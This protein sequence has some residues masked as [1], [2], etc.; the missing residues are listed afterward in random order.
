MITVSELIKAG[1]VILILLSGVSIYSIAI[2]LERW[3]AYRKIAKYY[4]SLRQKMTLL[5]RNGDLAPVRDF[6]TLND[7]PTSSILLS[8]LRSRA[9]KAEKREFANRAADKYITDISSRLSILATIGS[10]SPFIGLFGTVIGVMRAF[11]DL[12][13][14][15]GA[16]PSVVALGI[17]E[18]L[19]NTAAGLFVAVPAVVFY[20]WFANRANDFSSDLTWF[21]EQLIEATPEA[22]AVVRK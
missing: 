16:G 3:F 2:I 14:A 13:A 6:C 5:L 18:A 8:I 10:V 21:S 9:G 15:T 19:V 1:G 12:S 17:S 7:T 20:N 4:A 22:P 11:R